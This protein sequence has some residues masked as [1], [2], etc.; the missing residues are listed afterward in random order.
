[1]KVQTFRP[2]KFRHGVAKKV[3][4]ALHISQSAATMRLR[5]GNIEALELALKIEQAIIKREER[6]KAALEQRA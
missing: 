2:H 5:S 6:I 1:M 4:E 3:A